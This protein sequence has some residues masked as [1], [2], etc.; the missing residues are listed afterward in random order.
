MGHKVD[1]RFC[2]LV[3]DDCHP[4]TLLAHGHFDYLLRLAVREGIDPF[5]AI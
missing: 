3:T 5:E 2:C 4:D 1:T